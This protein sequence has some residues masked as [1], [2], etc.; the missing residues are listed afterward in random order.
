M[1]PF[2]AFSV[3]LC[4]TCCAMTAHAEIRIGR[5]GTETNPLGR[6]VTLDTATPR[7]AFAANR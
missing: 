1:K 4:V 3:V 7:E 2:F 6:S 5:I